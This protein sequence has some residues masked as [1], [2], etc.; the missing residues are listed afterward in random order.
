MER[1][2][3]AD[4]FP[5]AMALARDVVSACRILGDWTDNKKKGQDVR[6]LV[7]LLVDAHSGVGPKDLLEN[8]RHGSTE[9]RMLAYAILHDR[10]MKEQERL[11]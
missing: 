3:F 10:A 9:M 4:T 6:T 7:R 5:A 11:Q 2:D 8:K 1:V